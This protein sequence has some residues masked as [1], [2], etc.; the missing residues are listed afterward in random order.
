MTDCVKDVMGMCCKCNS[1]VYL[2]MTREGILLR[3]DYEA[4]SSIF[5]TRQNRK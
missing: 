4:N 5:F 2:K 3:Y 1:P